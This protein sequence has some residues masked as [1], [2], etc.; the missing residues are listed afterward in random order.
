MTEVTDIEKKSLEAHVELCARRYL[1]LETRLDNVDVKMETLNQMVTKV[2]D[3]IEHLANKRNDQIINWG[4]GI[5]GALVTSI[6][7][8][9]VHYV[10]K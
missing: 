10:I 6:G 1:S 8:L 7:Y 2:H 3:L 4:M 9:I 5:I